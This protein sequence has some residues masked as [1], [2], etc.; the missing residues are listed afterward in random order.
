MTHLVFWAAVL[1][2]ESS[3]QLGLYKRDSQ[4]SLLFTVGKEWPSESGQF[5][6]VPEG[7]LNCLSSV[8]KSVVFQSGG[9]IIS[10]P[11]VGTYKALL[12]PGLTKAL[13]CSFFCDV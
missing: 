13:L 8:L 12:L 10:C 2:L 7:I 5:Q 4:Q 3:L 11:P 9:N 1:V 6:G